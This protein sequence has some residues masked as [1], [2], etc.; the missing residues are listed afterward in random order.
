VG[1]L[2]GT[3]KA[4]AVAIARRAP[5]PRTARR[6]VVL[7]YH[8]VHPAKS[9]AIAP[10]RFE[11]QLEWVREH[12]DLIRFQDVFEALCSEHAGR[13]AVA[14]TFDDGY[15]DN[16]EYAFP[17]LRRYG[18]PATFFL[19]AGLMERDPAVAARIKVLQGASDEDVRP[20][21]WG[22]VREMRDAGMEFGAHTYGHPNLARLDR[23][24][25]ASELARSK[26]IVEQRTGRAVASMAYPFGT[27]KR[28]FT[29]ETVRLAADAGYRYAAT[30]T[31]RAVRPTDSRLAIPRVAPLGDGPQSV[32][33]MVSGAWDFLGVWQE[34]APRVIQHLVSAAK[35]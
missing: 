30:T 21:D 27:P 34:R 26:D 1:T 16:Y 31:F 19:I 15:A 11:A 4:L 18:A 32:R 2:K 25:A 6:V 10:D 24:R 12:C 35:R 33:D 7:C 8:S 9:F 17:L 29:A 13:P 22:H 28:S 3:F 5:A 20:L 23:A 14:I